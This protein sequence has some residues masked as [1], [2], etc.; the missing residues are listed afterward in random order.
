MSGWMF[1]LPNGKSLD[2]RGVLVEVLT[3]HQRKDAQYCS[4][5]WGVLGESHAEH[6]ADI[7]ED[8]VL[9]RI[10]LL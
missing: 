1:E 5:G 2:T 6:V 7:F 4:C 3:Y 9:Q 8:S 10:S